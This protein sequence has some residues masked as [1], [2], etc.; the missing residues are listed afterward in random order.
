MPTNSKHIF[1][2]SFISISSLLGGNLVLAQPEAAID[3]S[4]DTSP[5][6]DI[7]INSKS[8]KTERWQKLQQ[9]LNTAPVRRSANLPDNPAPDPSGAYIDPTGYSLG[10]TTGYEA[11]SS[12]V[13]K[14]RISGCRAVARPGLSSLCRPSLRQQRMRQLARS[15]N[16]GRSV[17]PLDRHSVANG[18]RPIQLGPIDITAEGFRVA[19]NLKTQRSVLSYQYRDPEAKGQGNFMFPLTVPSPVTSVFGWRVHPLF[20]DFS[21][22]SGTD[23]G[24]PLGTPVLAAYS[25]TVEVADYVGGYGL[26]VVLNHNKNTLQ[27][28][29]G[30]LSEIF[31][32]PGETI[33]Q[34]TVIGR[35]GSTGNSTGPHLHFETRQLTANGWIVAN[36]EAYLKTGLARLDKA[37]RLANSQPERHETAMPRTVREAIV[38]SASS[39]QFN[40]EI[41]QVDLDGLVARDPGAELESAL[42]QLVNALRGDRN[43][44]SR[45]KELGVRG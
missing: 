4:L 34:G 20:G 16:F 30:H 40:F 14:S 27:T 25:G 7:Q 43:A 38:A 31:V 35:V 5:S 8:V 13:L 22:H 37:I 42:V 33:P 21:F 32:S 41:K 15:R 39:T 2:I 29:Y 26:T 45:G 19:T 36:P 1:L 11:P 12:I 24:A 18:I 6:P 10:A 3:N 17:A 23:I 44:V 9:K 28:L